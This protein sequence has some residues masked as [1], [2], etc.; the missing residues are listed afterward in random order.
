MGLCRGGGSQR[1]VC[2]HEG[3]PELEESTSTQAQHA[4]PISICCGR[5]MVYVKIMDLLS[6][7]FCAS[8]VIQA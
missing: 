3:F 5:L 1:K 4:R 7:V 6:V 2:S 8:P